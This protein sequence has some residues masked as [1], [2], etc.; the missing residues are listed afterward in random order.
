MKPRTVALAL[1]A[2]LV[3]GDVAH[4]ADAPPFK[5]IR[6]D[7]SY[8]YLAD[9]PGAG[10]D[11]LRYIP[12]GPDAY[13]SLGGEARLRVD[14]FDAPRFG[15]AGARAD[16]YGLGRA[17]FSA[18][19]HLG[20]RVRI[21]GQLGLHRDFDKKDPPAVSDRSDVD[22]QVAFVDVTPDADRR[23]RL[24]LGRQEIAFNATQR[25]VSVRES[26]NIRQS[27]D[28]ARA[29]R[30]AADLRFDAFYVR[31]VTIQTGAFDDSS[32]RQQQFYGVYVSKT[33]S[34]AVSLDLYALELDRDGVR[35]GAVRGDERRTSYGAR[36]AGKRGAIDYEV[37][38]VIQGGRFAGRDI[39]AWAGSVGGG[40]TLVRPWSPR[41]GL[42]FDA[43]SGDKDPDDGELGT[44][45]P[46]F[47]KG[48]YFNETSLTSWSNLVAVRPSLGLAPSRDVSLELSYLMRWRQTGADAVY[49][50][51]S[52]PLAP[53]GPNRSKAV[54][55]AL[56]LDATWLV[57]R[58]L[59]LQGQLVHQSADDAVR[60]LGGRSVD[61]A[62]LI[63]QARF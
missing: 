62:M 33:L 17:L 36:L 35:F 10:L 32:N 45:N 53:V 58:N 7:E 16:L 31:P 28:G 60:A 4:A 23:W 15:V 25:F 6:S 20:S 12:L 41:L 29:T 57:S 8:A 9:K 39:Q 21:Y 55:D 34:K 61:F 11:D 2:A 49:L 43:G 47:P 27:F 50:Q 5:L 40:Y 59:K 13:L 42:R 24:R 48:S 46:L 1:A 30:Q 26:P 54:G 22:A 52:T 44:F 56:Q 14:S 37:E 3:I 18:D 63:V 38:G 51:P 19:L